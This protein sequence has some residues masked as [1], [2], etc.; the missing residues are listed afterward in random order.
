MY[1]NREDIKNY[2][3]KLKKMTAALIATV[4]Q[5]FEWPC[6]SF[7]LFWSFLK[8]NLFQNLFD[9]LKFVFSIMF[10]SLF[11]FRPSFV[12]IFDHGNT[13]DNG[14]GHSPLFSS[15]NLKQKLRRTPSAPLKGTA[16]DIFR[17][18]HVRCDIPLYS[19]DGIELLG[20]SRI[21]TI[22]I[23]RNRIR[24]GSD[25]SCSVG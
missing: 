16:T 3:E 11:R 2:E 1:W 21:G 18:S 14:N 19:A 15:K 4:L 9:L 17:G 7:N 12:S 22:H 20:F 23:P 6:F 13:A 8:L 24:S 10:T 25:P 5:S